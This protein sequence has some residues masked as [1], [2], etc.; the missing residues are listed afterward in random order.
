MVAVKWQMVSGLEVSQEWGER[1]RDRQTDK[2]V[3]WIGFSSNANKRPEEVSALL[4]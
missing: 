4:M 3:G 2:G 1:E